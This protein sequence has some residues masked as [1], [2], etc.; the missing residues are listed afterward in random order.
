[1]SKVYSFV[2]IDTSTM[3]ETALNRVFTKVTKPVRYSGGEWNSV[4]KDWESTDIRMVLAYPDLYEIG[5]SNLGLAI[6][7]DIANRQPYALTERVYAPWVDMEA[8]V[9]KEH[10]PLFSLESKRPVSDFDIIGFSLGYELTYTNVLNMLSL[11]GIPVHATERDKSHPLVIAGG[12]CVLNPEPM[13]EFID[14]FIMGDGEEVILELLSIM[15]QWKLNGS[16]D[17]QELFKELSAIR[18]I[19]V[20]QMYRVEYDSDGTV[21]AISST[22]EGL[23]D[24]VQR[25]IVDQLPPV[26]TRPV[27]PFM[28]TVHDRAAIEIQRGCT[29]GC[30]FCQAGVI[31]R[32]VRERPIGDV[33]SAADEL[34]KNTGYSELSLLSL[35]TSDY[36]DIEKL[37]GELAA[38]YKNDNLK[39]SLPSLRIDNRSVKLIDSIVWGKKTGLTFAPEAGTERLRQVI[40][41]SLSE[42]E[43]AQT[44][45]TAIE[46]G[47]SSVK[48]YFMIGLPGETPE[49][50]DGIIRLVHQS[51][52][53]KKG[54]GRGLNIKVSASSFVPKAHTPFQW[55]PQQHEDELRRKVDYLRN[56]LKKA[57][58]RLS[59]QDPRM[60]LLEGAMAR[61]DRRVSKIIHRAWQLGAKFD[62]WSEHF[63][64][65]RWLQAFDECGLDPAFYSERQRDMEECL[66][67]SHIDVG[68]SQSFLR[69]EYQNSLKG[70]ATGDCRSGRCNTCGLESRH[71]SCRA[72]YQS[73]SSS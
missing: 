68:V 65:D 4:V 36:A 23:H 11:S 41:K 54:G 55:V 15:R 2:I 9:R 21:S 12:S 66:P 25:R 51:G 20:P 63:D 60:S 19:Y 27:I 14:A 53:S 48:L 3:C 1:M 5:M 71:S 26:V 28:A 73:S 61:G 32:P 59:W 40:N 46:R 30:R 50:I 10:I 22:L 56:G 52:P 35:S 8:E 16:R 67:W 42:A 62:A 7:Y 38:R 29:R 57:G 24:T 39:L 13:A 64:Y 47:W 18:G 45:S 43:L 33:L 44:L 69:Q 17:K 6:I 58:V 72:S 37:V 31:Y 49:D 34:L 70:T